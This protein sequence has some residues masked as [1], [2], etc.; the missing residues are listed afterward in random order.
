LRQQ[1]QALRLTLS[2]INDWVLESLLVS[3]TTPTHPYRPR[4]AIRVKEWNL[5][6]LKPHWRGPFVIL[7]TPT[8]VK[9]AVIIP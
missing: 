4:D 9:V 8:I 2:K 1:R 6:P 7:C 5:Q 3:L